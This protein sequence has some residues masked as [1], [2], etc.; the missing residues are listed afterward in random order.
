MKK[1]RENKRKP[2]KLKTLVQ[3]N[4]RSVNCNQIPT[5]HNMTS[6]EY[7]KGN[8][9]HKA[10]PCHSHH[11]NCSRYW[12]QNKSLFCTCP[13]GSLSWS[14]LHGVMTAAMLASV[15]GCKRHCGCVMCTRG[16]C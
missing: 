6:K 14:R 8:N 4:S 5:L 11:C 16:A 15:S 7:W 3:A 1:K 12:Y 2:N 13:R 9:Q 10:M